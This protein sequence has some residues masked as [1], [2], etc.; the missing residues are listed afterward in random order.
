MSTR[1]VGL[2]LM[3]D[4]RKRLR[5]RVGGVL[6]CTHITELAQMLP[7]AVVQGFVGYVIDTRGT[8]EGATQAFPDRP[9]PC[10]EE[11]RPEVVRQHHAALVPAPG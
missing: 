9:L 5:E 6:G 1:L 7:T 2:N 10:P 3:Q 4:F 11:Q 8:A